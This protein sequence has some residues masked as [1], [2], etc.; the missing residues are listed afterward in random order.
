MLEQLIGSCNKSLFMLTLPLRYMHL[1][2]SNTTSK[3]DSNGWEQFFFYFLIG[4]ASLTLV[5]E[6]YEVPTYQ[7]QYLKAW[8][9]NGPRDVHQLPESK[10]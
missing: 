2:H 8:H 6:Y 7:A 10:T 5:L 3:L 1:L 9:T 4:H